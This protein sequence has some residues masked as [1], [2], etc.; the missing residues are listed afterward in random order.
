M[1]YA[2]DANLLLYAANADSDENDRAV[3]FLQ[4]CVDRGEVL[5][6]AWPTVMAF[7]RISTHPSIFP[8]PLSW[9]EAAQYVDTLLEVP[10]VRTLSELEGFWDLYRELAADLLPRGNLVPDLHLAAILRQNGVRTLYTNDRDF[11]KFGFLDV[12]DPFDS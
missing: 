9:E 12:R 4:E 1:S 11:L 10:H 7:L 5:C 8:A 2:I 3:Q 6:I